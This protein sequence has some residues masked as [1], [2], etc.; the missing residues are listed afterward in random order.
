[1]SEFC[2]NW[3]EQWPAVTNPHQKRATQCHHHHFS[4]WQT[5][6]YSPEV[7]WANSKQLK[8]VC[9]HTHTHRYMSVCI[10]RKNYIYVFHWNINQ[11][12]KAFRFEGFWWRSCVHVEDIRVRNSAWSS[13][14]SRCHYYKR[15]SFLPVVRSE[16][17][18]N[19]W[20]S[21]VRTE[22]KFTTLLFSLLALARSASQN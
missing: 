3:K 17:N 22:I 16:K 9:A 19:G 2:G 1:M 18:K 10:C 6:F 5:F 8:T 13:F 14:Q 7:P 4:Q 12:L 21:G 15:L 11:Q 20:W